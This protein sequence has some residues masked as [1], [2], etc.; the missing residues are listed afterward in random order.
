MANSPLNLWIQENLLGAKLAHPISVLHANG[1]VEVISPTAYSQ[2]IATLSKTLSKLGLQAGDSIFIILENSIYWD[3]LEKASL[4]CGVAV[5]AIETYALPESMVRIISEIKPRLVVVQTNQLLTMLS[6]HAPPL[7]KIIE[8]EEL[9]KLKQNSAD[10]IPLTVLNIPSEAPAKILYTSGT[11]GEPKALTYTHEQYFFAV[12]NVGRHFQGNS[13]ERT[14][15]WLPMSSPFQRMMNMTTLYLNGELWILTDPKAVMM[16]MKR[17]RPTVT[18]GVPRFYEK[19]YQA[20]ML[21]PLARI[22]KIIGL[23][24]LLSWQL[25]RLFGGKVKYLVSGSAPCPLHVVNLFSSLQLPLLEAYGTSENILPIAANTLQAHRQGSVGRVLSNQEVKISPEGEVLVKGLGV[26]VN[27]LGP[28]GYYHTKDLGY[29]DQDGF[30]FLT[31]RAN[32]V[33]KTSTGKKISLGSLEQRVSLNPHVEQVIAYAENRPF[34]IALV[35]IDQSMKINSLTTFMSE[36]NAKLDKHL[37]FGAVLLLNRSLS[38]ENNEL[39]TNLKYK[40]KIIYNNFS[41]EIDYIYS[42]IEQ[43]VVG[44]VNSINKSTQTWFR[45]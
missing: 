11:T 35:K 13:S 29:F 32:D 20:F 10:G 25:K 18:I 5:V 43:A 26:A 41:L 40:R 16:G 1:Q 39:T 28:D 24:R 3:W 22:L 31:G 42:H 9:I 21:N 23:N 6:P 2:G 4:L 34:V 37:R 14:L 33:V 8:L 44:E 36:V 27:Q 12:I 15:C 38:I 17:A 7:T 30:L 45:L 19:V